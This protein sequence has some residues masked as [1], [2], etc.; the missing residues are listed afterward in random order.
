[1]FVAFGMN[2]VYTFFEFR[3]RNG[4]GECRAVLY[5]QKCLDDGLLFIAV[6]IGTFL[7]VTISPYLIG[8][9]VQRFLGCI[10]KVL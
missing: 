4:L 1:M 8:K 5:H 2:I 7:N 9:I 10:V 6:Y 3:Y